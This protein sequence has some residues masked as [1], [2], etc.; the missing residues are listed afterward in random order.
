M[1]TAEWYPYR[2]AAARDL[3]FRYLDGLA[4]RLWPIVSE[5]RMIPTTF[6]ATF[7]RVS[8]PPTAPM[9][10]LAWCGDDFA[11]VGAEYRSAI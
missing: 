10:V 3:C 2:T 7:V 11:H 6:G 1:N 9:V 4:A 5:E 8:G